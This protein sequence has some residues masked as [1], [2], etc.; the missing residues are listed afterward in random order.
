MVP[1]PAG[2]Y[3]SD[4]T[5]LQGVV[6]QGENGTTLPAYTP[7]EKVF[8]FHF[9]VQV[10]TLD[11]M[12]TAGNQY[13]DPSYGLTYSSEIGFESQAVAGYAYEFPFDVGT[14]INHVF[15]PIAGSPNI[16]FIPVPQ[17]SM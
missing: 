15:T 10:P 12:P 11:G 3:G 2:G 16:R 14:G 6:G 5:N 7:L 9:I 8:A 17:M 13:Y 4:L 1:T